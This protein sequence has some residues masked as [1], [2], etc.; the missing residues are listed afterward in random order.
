MMPEPLGVDTVG[1]THDDPLLR[2][3]TV[4][5]EAPPVAETR[6]EERGDP[7]ISTT[8]SREELVLACAASARISA[9]LSARLRDR[10]RD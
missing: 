10:L 7:I 9:G 8:E 2:V 5:G 4:R 3:L 1:G 6:L